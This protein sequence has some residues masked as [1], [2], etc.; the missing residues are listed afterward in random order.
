MK[1]G[2]FG[3][4]VWE[5]KF[6]DNLGMLFRSA[7]AF[8]ADFVFTIGHRYKRD[9]VNTSKFERHIPL[10]HYVDFEDFKSHLPHAAQTVGIELT[11]EAT[12]LESFA[13][14]KQSVYL[15][16]GEDRTLPPEITSQLD[17]VCK[18]NTS[19]CTN[20]A[21]AGSIVLYDREA[22]AVRGIIE[23]LKV[24]SASA[25]DAQSPELLDAHMRETRQETGE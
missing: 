19:L 25:L 21:V 2:Y 17:S 9:Y 1:K 5:P 23:R 6:E 7:H 12:P 15:L 13:H 11:D 4:G 8:G 18:F 14:P 3:I 22:K 16:G 20:V 24:R 10:Y